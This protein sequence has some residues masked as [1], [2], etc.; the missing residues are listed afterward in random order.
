MRQLPLRSLPWAACNFTVI[1]QWPVLGYTTQPRRRPLKTGKC[2]S[3]G[4]KEKLSRW[5]EER[6]PNGHATYSFERRARM[7]GRRF[8]WNKVPTDCGQCACNAAAVSFGLQ[9]PL[10]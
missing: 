8:T 2:F 1:L 7:R 4:T 10:D 6:V 9:C 3:G 5:M